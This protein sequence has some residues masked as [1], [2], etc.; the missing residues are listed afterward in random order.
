LPCLGN[1]D[2]GRFSDW[3]SLPRQRLA[4]H[5]LAYLRGFDALLRLTYFLDSSAAVLGD[6]EER[7]RRLSVVDELCEE[8]REQA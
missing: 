4:M 3:D 2:A 8:T 7:A 5:D 1:V 6:R